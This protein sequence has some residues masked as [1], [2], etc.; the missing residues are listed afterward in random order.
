LNNLLLIRS[1]QV[2][3]L[4]EAE[5]VRDTLQAIEFQ[6]HCEI[7]V[8]SLEVK[9]VKSLSHCFSILRLHRALLG[10]R[11]KLKSWGTWQAETLRCKISSIQKSTMRKS[12][13]NAINLA[14]WSRL[15]RLPVGVLGSSGD[16]HRIRKP[17]GLAWDR[18]LVFVRVS[19]QNSVFVPRSL[20]SSLVVADLLTARRR[21]HPLRFSNWPPATR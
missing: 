2:C 17:Q 15:C 9:H 10:Q 19:D 7:R 3:G 11:N 20:T 21:R 8:G 18:H 6:R 5:R 14:R 1:F 13:R 4:D 12:V 16:R